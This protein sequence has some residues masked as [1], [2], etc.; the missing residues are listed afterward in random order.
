M[1]SRI[2]SGRAMSFLAGA[3]LGAVT[4]YFFDPKEGRRRRAVCTDQFRKLWHDTR[5]AAGV[6]GRDLGHRAQGLAAGARHLVTPD[7]T[8]DRVVAERVRAATTRSS[9]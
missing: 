8:D 4:M 2:N 3:A 9:V 1:E 7:H 6:I 5:D